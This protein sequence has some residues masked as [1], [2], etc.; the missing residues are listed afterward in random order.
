MRKDLMDDDGF[1]VENI[2]DSVIEFD[3]EHRTLWDKTIEDLRG[4]G[5]LRRVDGAA[6]CGYCVHLVKWRKAE[7][8]LR[9]L[10]KKTSFL[11]SVIVK[12]SGGGPVINPLVTLSDKACERTIYYAS[13]L[14]MTPA[15]RLRM[16]SSMTNIVTQKANIFTKL[17][18]K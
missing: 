18:G 8:D 16:E 5:I 10:E 13:Q 12:G 15:S 9:A 14:G 11:K 4:F 6:L 3:E 17:K 7:R 1:K 2:P